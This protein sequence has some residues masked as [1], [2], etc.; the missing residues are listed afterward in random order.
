MCG[1]YP[2]TASTLAKLFRDL[3]RPVHPW[4][5]PQ[6]LSFGR[7]GTAAGAASI[8]EP[9]DHALKILRGRAV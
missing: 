5:E 1:R 9:D 6:Q 2:H 7:L 3:G 8:P 4:R